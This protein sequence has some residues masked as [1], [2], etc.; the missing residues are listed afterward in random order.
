MPGLT[1]CVRGTLWLGDT[2]LPFVLF[3]IFLAV[4]G[5]AWHTG[6]TADCGCFGAW[7]KRTPQQA[8]LEDLFMLAGLTAAWVLNRREAIGHS[9]LKL[10]A[11]VMATILGLG[12]TL[13]LVQV[14]LRWQALRCHHCDYTVPIPSACPAC[15]GLSLSAWGA[16][17]EQVEAAR[18]RLRQSG[19]V[20]LDERDSSC[21][22]ARQDKV[23]VADPAGNRW[24]VYTVL[25]DI[26]EDDHHDAAAACCTPVAG[27]SPACCA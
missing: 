22:Y 19:L 6:A 3:L 5:W 10:A 8:L 13:F 2:G 1:C 17:T 15:G 12:V 24:E 20:T 27:E 11:V 21:C 16:G 18:I 4:L 23:W 14:L 26:E 7:V 25:G 9:S